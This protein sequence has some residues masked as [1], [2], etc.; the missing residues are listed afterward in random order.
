V[1]INIKKYV[2]PLLSWD[3][4]EYKTTWR[5]REIYASYF[6]MAGTFDPLELGVEVDCKYPYK[7]CMKNVFTSGTNRRHIGQVL[8]R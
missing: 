3:F 8:R 4:F 7:F 1:A 5:P 2:R 6:L